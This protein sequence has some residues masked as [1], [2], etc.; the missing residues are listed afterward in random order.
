MK[1]ISIVMPVYNSELYLGE[2]IESI[3]NQTFKDFELICINDGSTDKSLEILN[4]FNKKYN[5]FIKI[6]STENQG[7]GAARNFGF[8]FV[9]GETTIFL[10]SDDCFYPNLLEELYNQYSK[11]K[12]DITICKYSIAK[13]NG[14]IV[15]SKGI[16]YNIL[17]N[18]EIFNKYDIPNFI[19]NFTNYSV[20][21][22]LYN[23]DFIKK[24]N[25]QFENV[26]IGN[27]VFFCLLSLFLADKITTIR[28][29][30][31]TYN[32]LNKNSITSQ[33]SK[34]I[35]TYQIETYKK[36]EKLIFTN[37]KNDIF[38]KS[39]YNEY[40]S[41]VLK[42]LNYTRGQVRINYINKI[43]ENLKKIPPKQDFYN[44]VNYYKLLL[45]QKL[46]IWLYIFLYYKVLCSLSRFFK[47]H[48]SQVFNHIF[49]GFKTL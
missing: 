33:K 3:R 13:P 38:K 37:F 14:N 36:L 43:K 15:E 47:I 2:A 16:N 48:P 32:T 40:I 30:L 46:P 10:D 5:N 1:K 39:F 41:H 8:Q 26:P 34:L 6:I 18:K 31:I 17:S 12:A 23:T 28:K 20:R 7:A 24:Y 9:E 21:N 35:N 45:I 27:D 19:F 49:C 44:P 25:I 22:K 29:N 42:C 4:N 11:T